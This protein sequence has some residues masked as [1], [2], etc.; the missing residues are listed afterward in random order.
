MNKDVRQQTQ[1]P[2]QLAFPITRWYFDCSL[3]DLQAY[4]AETIL[5]HL[6]SR[7]DFALDHLQ[8]DSWLDQIKHL[9]KT[10]AGITTGHLFFEYTIPRMGRRADVIIIVG[11]SV[12]VVEYKVGTQ[13]YDAAAKRQTMGYALDLENF[14][15]G[16]HQLRIIPVLVATGA[17]EGP[18]PTEALIGST[19]AVGLTAGPQLQKAI[20]AAATAT[21]PVIDPMKWAN[22]RYKPTPT[23]I[24]AAISLYAG[25]NVADISRSDAGAINLTTTSDTAASIIDNA[26]HTGEKAIIFISGVPGSGKTLA[27]LNIATN[28]MHQQEG[29]HAVF[30]SGNGPLVEVLRES[31][32]RDEVERAKQ[33]G[34]RRTKEEA[35]RN[36]SSFIQN[37]HHFRN[38]ALESTEAPIERVAIFDEAQRAWDEPKTA[39]FMKKNRGLKDW[40]QSEPEFLISAMDRHKGWCVIVCLIGNGQEIHTGEAGI[41]EWFRA[42]KNS[43]PDWKAYVPS[44]HDLQ[45]SE[46]ERIGCAVSAESRPGLHLSSSIRSFRSEHVAAWVDA[47]LHGEADRATDL[48]ANLR[49]YPIH[50]SRDLSECRAWLRSQT[51]GTDR[52]GLVAS[53]NAIRLKPHGI[54]VKAGISVKNWFLDWEDDV[55]SSQ[56]LEDV[57]TEF[58]VQGLELDWTTVCWDANLRYVTSA[59][60]THRFSG[61]KWKNVNKGADQRYLVNAYRVLLT[62][63]RQGMVIYVPEGDSSDPTRSSKYYDGTYEH[64]IAC[65]ATPL[66]TQRS[67]AESA[68][69]AQQI[70]RCAPAMT[71]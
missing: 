3:V 13:V 60:E 35:L 14:H 43:Y 7:H 36:A 17:A 12:F 58:D 16:S 5:G 29:E 22:S 8:R 50:I 25:H 47:V 31:L 70:T 59:W 4:S 63:A 55:R 27:G 39:Q 49:D 19:R 69:S 21:G 1:G 67:T 56:A 41:T 6:A 65:G 23:I 37:V 10:L 15:E 51:H 26:K 53:S 24:E 30:L 61:S 40:G 34:E 32:A 64:L 28:R 57:G 71:P 68:T 42:I 20:Q 18:M 48:Q 44:G 46:I 54:H 11:S 52:A 62:R 9:K 45:A 33:R 66:G 38:E 2:A